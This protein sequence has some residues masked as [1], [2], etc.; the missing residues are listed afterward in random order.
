MKYHSLL[1]LGGLLVCVVLTGCATPYSPEQIEYTMQKSLISAQKLADTGK[2]EEAK[3]LVGAMDEINPNYAGL[4]ELET[5]CGYEKTSASI[6]GENV[7]RRAKDD[8]SIITRIILY[9]PDRVFDLLD[10]FSFDIHFGGGVFA[11]A[12]ATRALQAGA[13]L[14]SVGGLGWH[15]YRSLG[16]ESQKEAGLNVLALGAQ[17]YSATRVGTSGIQETSQG[18]AG[19]H[20]PSDLIYQEYR[21][22]W[23]VGGSVTAV[24]I[25]FDFD[26]HPVQIVDFLLGFIGI[27]ICNDDFAGTRMVSLSG[28]DKQ[29][30]LDLA[31]IKA[32]Q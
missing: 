20:F 1:T 4:K 16:V 6:L 30:L 25:G 2:K 12:H 3:L 5:K 13:G 11:N 21:D 31:H 10:I 22:Y 26:V 14:R 18:M 8:S 24:F 28:L 7:R 19:I 32:R 15:D 17:G 29:L 27:D 23:A 9:V